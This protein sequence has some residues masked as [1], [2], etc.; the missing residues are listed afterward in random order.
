M[1]VCEILN[2]L[3]IFWGDVRSDL[4]PGILFLLH[5]L[6]CVLLFARCWHYDADNFSD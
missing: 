6:Y 2:R 3:I 4:D 1:N 5:L